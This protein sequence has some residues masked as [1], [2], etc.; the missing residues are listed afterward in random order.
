MS[1]CQQKN[2]M[3]SARHEQCKYFGST[4]VIFDFI[5]IYVWG[6]QFYLLLDKLANKLRKIKHFKQI[7]DQ[8]S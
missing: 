1:L 4:Q 3:V 7:Q 6:I 8:Q 2:S 5:Y